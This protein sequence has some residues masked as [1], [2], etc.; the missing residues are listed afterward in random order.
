MRNIVQHRRYLLLL[1]MFAVLIIPGTAVAQNP[2]PSDTSGGEEPTPEGETSVVELESGEKAVP[3]QVIV[4]FKEEASGTAKEDTRSDEGLEKKEDLDL[5]DAEVDKLEGQSVEEA[6]SNLEAHPEVEYAEPDHIVKLEGYSNE[7]RFGELWGLHNTGQPINGATG[8][9]D[10]DINAPEASAITQ[11]DKDLV[12]AVID[13]G[14]DFTHPDL[15]GRQWTN[16][17]ESGGGK[18]TN[19]VDDD[20]NGFVDDVNG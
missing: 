14:V 13:D 17:G 11:G 19:G 20:K 9:D 2:E 16:P 1:L 4:K 18:E 8:T 12:V 7:R 10:V 3:D 5:I 6:I 15:A